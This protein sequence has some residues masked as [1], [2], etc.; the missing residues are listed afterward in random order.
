MKH[1]TYAEILI[2]LI[3]LTLGLLGIRSIS[4]NE[5]AFARTQS[6]FN[7]V[8][9]SAIFDNKRNREYLYLLDV[10]NGD[11]WKYNMD[12]PEDSPK[13]IG[14]LSEIGKPLAKEQ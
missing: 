12:S 4:Q 5:K 13:Y 11:I 2:I 14:K 9:I 3:A 1:F 6:T 7:Y 10:R 8:Q